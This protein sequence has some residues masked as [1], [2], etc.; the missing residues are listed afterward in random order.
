MQDSGNENHP[1]ILTLWGG[2]GLAFQQQV[3]RLQVTMVQNGYIYQGRE[4]QDSKPEGHFQFTNHNDLYLII[5][6]VWQIKWCWF[7]TI[8]EKA[9]KI[10]LRPIFLLNLFSYYGYR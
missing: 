10:T 8:K 9:L 6:V 2:R 4:G 3:H 5:K 1:K 7:L